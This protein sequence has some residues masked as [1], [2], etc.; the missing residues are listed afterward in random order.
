MNFMLIVP[1]ASLEAREICSEISLAESSSLQALVVVFYHNDLQVWKKPFTAGSFAITCMPKDQV[2]HLCSVAAV[3]RLLNCKENSD[4]EQDIS[5]LMSKYQDQ[6]KRSF[7]D[8]CI[9]GTF[10]L[11]IKDR[12]RDYHTLMVFQETVQFPFVVRLDVFQFCF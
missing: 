9:R 11:G 2:D 3:E 6:A 7:V 1:E 4:Y 8:V 12:V 5:S 10:D